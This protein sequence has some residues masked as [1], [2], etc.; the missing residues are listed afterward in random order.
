MSL[1]VEPVVEATDTAL[2]ALEAVDVFRI[3]RTGEAE[4]V[5]L[6]GLDL[7]VAAG[8]MVAIL[9]P[10]GCGKSTFLHLAAGLDQ[11]SAGE[12]RAFGR[13][14]GR[15]AEPELA[16]YRARDMAIVFQSRNLLGHLTAVEN[17][18]LQLGLAGVDDAEA[19]ARAALASFGLGDRSATRAAS[20]SGG[21][22]QRAAI[23]ACAAR[24]ARLV[25]CDEPTGE[26]DTANEARVIEA[27][28][29]LQM[30]HGAT[31]VIVTHSTRVADVCDRVVLMRDGRV[32]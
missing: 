27:L 16:R 25:L 31:V 5:A 3:F 26:L 18:A 15:L 21:E 29:L 9:G 13:P 2:P 24:T 32:A 10:S 20:L 17:V 12:V 30:E 28:Q 6:R 7:D 11:P 1:Y 14:L 8:S 22:Q 19:K 4:T 23:A